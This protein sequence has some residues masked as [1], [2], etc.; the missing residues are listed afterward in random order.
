MV[1]KSLSH[2][3]FMAA[4]KLQN[5][6]SFSSPVLLSLYCKILQSKMTPAL[7]LSRVHVA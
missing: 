2:S 1:K 7:N 3:L 4:V 6:E 5:V